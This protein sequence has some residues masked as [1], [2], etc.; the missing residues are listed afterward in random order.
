MPQLLNQCSGVSEPQLLSPHAV[1]MEASTLHP[2]LHNKEKTPKWRGAPTYCNER[3]PAC[4]KDPPQPENNK[5]IN[6]KKRKADGPFSSQYLTMSSWSLTSACII[7]FSG[8]L[9]VLPAPTPSNLT[10]F[11]CNFSYLY[12]RMSAKTFHSTPPSAYL[13]AC[14][15]FDKL[16]IDLKF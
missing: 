14:S 11:L 2:V 3:K 10:Y 16:W 1:I 7:F 13:F 9:F 6:L 4:N 8:F 12:K 15:L 5:I